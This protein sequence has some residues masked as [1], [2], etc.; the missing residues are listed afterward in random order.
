MTTPRPPT[1][2]WE[3]CYLDLEHPRSLPAPEAQRSAILEAC[4][5]VAL[6]DA[7][8]AEAEAERQAIRSSF[9]SWS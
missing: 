4:A 8:Q 3:A 9:H 1:E 7:Q 5:R 2:Y 6:V